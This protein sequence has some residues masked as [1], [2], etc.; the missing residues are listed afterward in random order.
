M[1]F[2]TAEKQFN[3]DFEVI[4]EDTIVDL[5]MTIRPGH[6]GDG[7]WLTQSKSSSWQYLDCEFTVIGGEFNKRK[8]WQNMMYANH[9]NP[10]SK[11]ID[12]TRSTLRAVLESARNINP[13]DESD[14][15]KAGRQINGWDD[16]N[17][18]Q[19]RAKLKIEAGQN[20]F[21]DKNQIKSV[22]VPG[23][24]DYGT[25]P[26]QSNVAPMTTVGQAADNVVQ[27]AAQNQGS[28]VPAWAQS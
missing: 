15:A 24:D 14:Q 7:G 20:G 3:T 8:I 2:N 12:I 23:M 16:F 25:A 18:L 27:Q 19:F 22:I 17:G 11:A 5:I 13:K 9:E 21:S 28:N 10:S 4:P 26:V 1:D 6:A